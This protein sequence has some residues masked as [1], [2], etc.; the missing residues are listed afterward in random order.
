M[1]ELEE[2]CAK[3]RELM[4]QAVKRNLA[5]GIML[6]GGLDTSILAAIASK[7]I[8][9]KAF[10]CAFQ[11]APAPDIEH[12]TLMAKQLNLPH[13]IHYFAEEELYEAARFVIKLLKVFDPM[14]VRNSA[15][16]CIGVNLA[17]NNG[18]KSIMTGDALDEL[19]AGYPW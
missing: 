12:A 13:Y 9:L 3:I 15:T 8:R 17:K 14:E 18:V 7:Y 2:I 4:D 10:T 16:V 11:G 1:S 5:E 19:M 6:S